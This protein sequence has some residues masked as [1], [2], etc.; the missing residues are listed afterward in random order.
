NDLAKSDPLSLD[1][2]EGLS[3]FVPGKRVFLQIES[4]ANNESESFSNETESPE[5]GFQFRFNQDKTP[6][7]P[8]NKRR[9]PKNKGSS[10]TA[11]SF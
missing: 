5:E 1:D 2:F 7:N 6:A 8:A 4:E 9:A 10:D 3:D 11:L